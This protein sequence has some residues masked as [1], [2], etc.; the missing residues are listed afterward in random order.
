M[1]QKLVKNKGYPCKVSGNNHK[2]GDYPIT[3]DNALSPQERR[4]SGAWAVI[5]HLV[6]Q[7]NWNE[8]A[9]DLGQR[10]HCTARGLRVGPLAARP[11]TCR[12]VHL[13]HLTS[14]CL[15]V[16]SFWRETNTTRVSVFMASSRAGGGCTRGAEQTVFRT[17]YKVSGYVSVKKRSPLDFPEGVQTHH[18]WKLRLLRIQPGL[19]EGKGSVLG[20]NSQ[21]PPSE[22]W[23]HLPN[24]FSSS[25]FR[26]SFSHSSQHTA[27]IHATPPTHLQL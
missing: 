19:D 2:L 1:L 4:H 5:L 17:A 9:W 13:S 23:F 11:N 26:P 24:S 22:L 18:F 3:Q 10:G 16:L 6:S 14:Q 27:A 20:V 12:C 7:A 25:A 15:F 21:L 8:G